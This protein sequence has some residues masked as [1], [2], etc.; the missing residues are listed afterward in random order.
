VLGFSTEMLKVQ[1]SNQ[2]HIQ[3]GGKFRLDYSSHGLRT[4][5]E[6]FFHRNSKLLGLGRQI[7]QMNFGAFGVFS[8]DLSAPT[9]V[10]WVPCSCFPLI[11][12]YFYKKLSLYIH[13]PN[14]YV[15]LGFEFEFE[16]EPQRI[17]DFVIV[18][19]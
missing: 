3:N 1:D 8:A 15:G 14:I 10:L 9:L 4:P 2:D 12:Q 11:N 17:K 6:A 18:F 7:V 16:F 5:N 19:P 13:I